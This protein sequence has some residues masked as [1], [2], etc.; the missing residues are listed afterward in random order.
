MNDIN[1]SEELLEAIEKRVEE[2]KQENPKLKKV[3]PVGVLV[4]R[5]PER[6]RAIRLI[7]GNRTLPLFRS[8]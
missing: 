4:I 7:Y 5:K 6:K 2:I 3:Y 8:L 1:V